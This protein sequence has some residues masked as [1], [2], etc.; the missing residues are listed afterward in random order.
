MPQLV[1]F[2]RQRVVGDADLVLRHAVVNDVRFVSDH[3]AMALNA[4][5][6][7]LNDPRNGAELVQRLH[8]LRHRLRSVVREAEAN[9][10]TSDPAKRWDEFAAWINGRIAESVQENFVLAHTRSRDLA[11]KVAARFAEEGQVAVPQLYLDSPAR[12]STRSS[13]WSR[14]RPARPA[15]CSG[16]S[17]ACAGPTVAS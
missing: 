8:D 15:W 7:A 4:E 12:S 14:W 5:L 3:L 1:D 6:D 13:P 2:L 11:A 10:M 16:C 9:I 17:P